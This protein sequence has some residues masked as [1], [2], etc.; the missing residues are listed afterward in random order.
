MYG[1]WLKCS[2]HL[3][4]GF[5]DGRHSH[6]HCSWSYLGTPLFLEHICQHCGQDV[7]VSG[8][9]GLCCQRSEDRIPRHSAFNDTIN[10]PWQPSTFLLPLNQ[11]VSVMVMGVR[12]IP[13]RSGRA[14]VWD[15]TYHNIFAPSN[16]PQSCSFSG[17]VAALDHYS[18]F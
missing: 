9:H 5:A 7:N 4:F 2:P 8:M 3:L 15:V 10:L 14:L 12:I 18:G 17:C 13:W 11:K 6:H 1:V 16:I